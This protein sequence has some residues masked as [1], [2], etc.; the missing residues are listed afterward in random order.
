MKAIKYIMKESLLP[1]S[2]GWNE[3]NEQIAKQEA[4]NG[5]IEIVEDAEA[6]A[7]VPTIEER[8]NELTEAVNLLLEGAQE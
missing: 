6:A 2:I 5:E 1:V 4:H 8:L 3:A 7:P